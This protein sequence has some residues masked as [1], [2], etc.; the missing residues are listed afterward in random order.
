MYAIRLGVH[1][2]TLMQIFVNLRLSM[3]KLQ[4]VEAEPCSPKKPKKPVKVGTSEYIFLYKLD[5]DL[6]NSNIVIGNESWFH[7]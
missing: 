4:T 6:F 5:P 1:L 7:H 2:D 3:W